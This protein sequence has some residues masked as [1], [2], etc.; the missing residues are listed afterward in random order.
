MY[1]I[2]RK[3]FE[4]VLPVSIEKAWSFFSDPSNLQTITP[5]YM[6]FIIHSGKDDHRTYPGQIIVYT[7]SPVM[8][9]PMKWV[10][11]ITHVQEPFYFVDEQR[12]GPYKLWHHQHH[13]KSI[14]ANT[15]LMTDILH[16]SIPAGILGRLM[17]SIMISRKV[18]SIFT[19]R[20]EKLK[21]LFR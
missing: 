3:Q 17:N 5:E 7:V 18:D 8:N 10:T 1:M 9:V 12:Q 2:Y 14:D 13:F 6:K 16:Y 20:T 4:Q 11:E 15:T 21:Q 19:Y